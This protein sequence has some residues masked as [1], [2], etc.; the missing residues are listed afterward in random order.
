MTETVAGSGAKP[1]PN[2]R[3]RRLP[4]ICGCCTIPRCSLICASVR[5]NTLFQ[6]SFACVCCKFCTQCQVNRP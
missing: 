4:S 5:S 1:P 6:V 3:W 2:T